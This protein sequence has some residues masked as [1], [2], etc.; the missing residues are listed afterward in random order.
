M[1]L[2]LPLLT[3]QFQVITREH[4]V[5]MPGT[6]KVL[7][8]NPERIAVGFSHAGSATNVAIF[9]FMDPAIR[10]RFFLLG[11]SS[12]W[13]Y[14][15]KHAAMVPMQWMMEVISLAGDTITSIEIWQAEPK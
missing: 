9:P 15:Y 2:N 5:V 4:A 8:A 3:S 7:D 10:V 11:D 12:Q 13:F 1:A 6:T 14:W